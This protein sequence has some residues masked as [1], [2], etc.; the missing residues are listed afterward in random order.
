MNFKKKVNANSGLE[1]VW[2]KK[3]TLIKITPAN[4]FAII[5]FQNCLYNL[6]L[7]LL[8]YVY[9]N[10]VRIFQKL[11]LMSFIFLM[12]YG[13]VTHFNNSQTCGT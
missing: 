7:E 4:L 1:Y 5:K 12:K 3:I 11:L 2:Q 6:I 8:L 9:I 10:K 13:Q